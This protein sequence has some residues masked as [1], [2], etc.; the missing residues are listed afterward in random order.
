VCGI[1]HFNKD[2]NKNKKTTDDDRFVKKTC[3][4]SCSA[5]ACVDHSHEAKSD[6]IKK[7]CT[8]H[9]INIFSRIRASTLQGFGGREGGEMYIFCG[10]LLR[11]YCDRV[12]I[13]F[14]NIETAEIKTNVFQRQ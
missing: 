13:F 12:V 8:I 2:D 4:V 14:C 1:V 10:L 3:Y 11:K 9:K 7:D 6:Q 5:G